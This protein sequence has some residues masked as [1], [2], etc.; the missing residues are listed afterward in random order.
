MDDIPGNQFAREEVDQLPFSHAVA[1]RGDEFG[2]RLQRL[3]GAILL[4]ESDGDD[5]DDGASD[6]NRV[7][8]LTQKNRDKSGSQEQQDERILKNIADMTTGN[9]GGPTIGRGRAADSNLL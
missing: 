9:F 5:D 8:E 1:P 4:D 3:L 6:R 2:E 7:V